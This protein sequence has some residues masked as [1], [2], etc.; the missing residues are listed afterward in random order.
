MLG[1]LI[2]LFLLTP[3][4]ELGLLIQVDKLIG[5]WPTIGLIIV[6]GMAGS[7][8][9]KREGL[10][11][12]NRLNERLNGG[13]LP[14]KELLDGVIILVAGALLITPGVLTDVFGFIGLIPFTRAGV[15][16]IVMKRIRKKM[17]DGSF[18]MQFGFF[19]GSGPGGYD[20]YGTPGGFDHG[21]VQDAEWEPAG[22]TSEEN[23]ERDARGNGVH[24]EVTGGGSEQLPEPRS[25]R[26]ERNSIQGQ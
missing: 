16:K 1:R 9:A 20:E 6:T 11:V 2:L 22:P 3:A 15:R 5:F 19:G 12:W 14:G 13:G 8:L 17:D 26:D 23:G 4:V 24:R 18:Q 25:G 10:S 21:G 7:Y